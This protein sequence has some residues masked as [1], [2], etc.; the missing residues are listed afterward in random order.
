MIDFHIEI[1]FSGGGFLPSEA[2][3]CARY[4]GFK[5]IGL[6]LRADQASYKYEIP[7]LVKTIRE[8]SIYSG[9]EAFVGVLFVHVPPSLLSDAICSVRELGVQL[10]LVHGEGNNFFYP[11][12]S[13]TGT[14]FAA[15]SA[16][17]DIL[18]YPGLLSHEDAVF[19]AEKG[20]FIELTACNPYG[21]F[22]G[23][24]VQLYRTF[25]FKITISSGILKPGYF[26]PPEG[27]K[28]TVQMIGLG[29][30]LTKSQLL[31]INSEEQK[32][33][34]SLLLQHT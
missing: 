16:G 23:H 4:S 30:G 3:A 21:V 26:S 1:S 19:A 20:V 14:N 32:F 27:T 18:A 17:A 15:I 34:H 11:H 2:L 5:A 25:G 12:Q 31:H 22:N 24:I 7:H 28:H 8:Y 33:V 9:I 13:A 10:V 29:S 6:I